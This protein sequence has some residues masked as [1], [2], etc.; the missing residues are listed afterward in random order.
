MYD[1]IILIMA[2]KNSKRIQDKNMK[3]FA[4]VNLIKYT[5]EVAKKLGVPTVVC[6]DHPQI[7]KL[8]NAWYP[9]FILIN[10]PEEVQEEKANCNQSMK[11]VLSQ[12]PANIVIL[13]QPTCPLRNWTE[14]QNWVKQFQNSNMDCGLSVVENRK[15]LYNEDGEW[16]NPIDR[17]ANNPVKPVLYQET[18]S[19]Y[20][21]RAD[22][23]GDNHIVHG[24]KMFFIDQFDIDLDTEKD[25][26]KEELLI[27][28]GYYAE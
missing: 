8:V 25:W 20:M 6:T 11:W 19:V 2:R 28:G 10:Q 7:K 21:F 1:K 27:A 5:L 13:L 15:Y 17:L 16:I 23:L 24:K 9:R 14:I 22:R 3:P 18:G 26:K 4:G 12:V